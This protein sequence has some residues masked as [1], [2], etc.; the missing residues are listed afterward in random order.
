MAAK[1]FPERG[2]PPAGQDVRRGPRPVVPRPHHR[3]TVRPRP[4]RDAARRGRRQRGQGLHEPGLLPDLPA[5]RLEGP[6]GRRDARLEGKLEHCTIVI[7]KIS[8]G[9]L[10]L[11]LGDKSAPKKITVSPNFDFFFWGGVMFLG[12]K[13]KSFYYCIILHSIIHLIV[14]YG[15]EAIVAVS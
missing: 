5:A 10:I 9:V 2:D 14:K 1:T 6:H 8:G 3:A 11:R 7:M 12:N 4:L 13:I 15:H